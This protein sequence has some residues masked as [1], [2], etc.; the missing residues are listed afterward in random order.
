MQSFTSHLSMMPRKAPSDGPTRGASNSQSCSRVIRAPSFSGAVSNKGH[1]DAQHPPAPRGAPGARAAAARRGIA[2][3]VC[4]AGPLHQLHP[5]PDRAVPGACAA[6]CRRKCHCL[7]P[8]AE[9]VLALTDPLHAGAM[10]RPGRKLHR[11]RVQ[12]ERHVAVRGVRGGLHLLP[13]HGREHLGCMEPGAA[14]PCA[15]PAERAFT[16]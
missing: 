9:G 7:A 8:A 2:A 15:P 11:R 5:A 13:L 16:C 14:A 10:R 1:H 4:R 6:A 12:Q 3:G